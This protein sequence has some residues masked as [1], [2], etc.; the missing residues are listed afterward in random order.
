MIEYSDFEKVDIRVGTVIE[1]EDFPEARKPA[2]KLKIDLGEEIGVKNSSVQVV[3][4]Y[5]SD[6][7][8]NRQVL[9]I[10]NFSPKQIGPF[11]SEVLVL[12]VPDEDGECVLLEVKKTVP[13]GGKIY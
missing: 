13:N 10:V 4:N 2:Y 1:V 5:N 6:E 3:S 8:L 9:A 12:G 7:L 11:L